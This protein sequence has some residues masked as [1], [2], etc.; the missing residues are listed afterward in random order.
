MDDYDY[1]TFSESAKSRHNYIR[2]VLLFLFTQKYTYAFQAH[3]VA[4]F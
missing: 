1:L 2:D 4:L 3:H